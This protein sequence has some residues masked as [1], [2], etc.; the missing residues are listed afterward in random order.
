MGAKGASVTKAIIYTRFSP[1][2]DADES[3][4]CERQE[5]AC[6]EYCEKKRYEVAD[7]FA[8][9]A[10]SGDDADRPGLWLA[11]EGL[12]RGWV[13][14]VRDR[15]RLARDVY[16]S[17]VVRRAV[18][19]G[20]ARIEAV[21]ETNGDTPQ[22]CLIRQILAAFAEYEKKVISSRTK[23]AMLRHQAAGRRMS[24]IAPYGWTIDPDNPAL[25]VR[26]E[27]EEAIIGL[28]RELRDAGMSWRAIAAELDRRQIP[29]KLGGSWT[30]KSVAK[31][32]E[33]GG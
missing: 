9:R 14:V 22:D 19:K 13:L 4:S 30:H 12:R 2:P 28:M 17:E 23:Y 15:K 27:E 24:R 25:L 26:N 18:E 20:G 32:V 11:I 3:E 16:L 6:R 5:L 21:E 8:D 10:L 29:P 31:I 7:A 1:R 33:R